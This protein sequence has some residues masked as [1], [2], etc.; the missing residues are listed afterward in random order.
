[1][2]I[3]LFLFFFTYTYTFLPRSLRVLFRVYTFGERPALHTPL[4]D[5]LLWRIHV[6]LCSHELKDGFNYSG[7]ILVTV[8]VRFGC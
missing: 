6:A 3:C 5:V 8:W 1:M 7:I 2:P 4:D